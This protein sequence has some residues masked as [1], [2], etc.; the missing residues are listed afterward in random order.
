MSDGRPWV[1]AG[2]RNRKD[3]SLQVCHNRADGTQ[4]PSAPFIV[5]NKAILILPRLTRSRRLL[6]IEGK[7]IRKFWGTEGRV[8]T[9]ARPFLP[10]AENF[11]LR[12]A[13]LCFCTRSSF[14]VPHC[15]SKRISSA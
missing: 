9:R 1:L 13:I 5:N 8:R 12:F 10:S 14:A 3:V 11:R 15:R 6:E 2:E 4:R 7:R